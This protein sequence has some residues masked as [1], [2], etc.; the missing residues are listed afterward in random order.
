MTLLS[1]DSNDSKTL[2]DGVGKPHRIRKMDKDVDLESTASVN[3]VCAKDSHHEDDD[4]ILEEDDPGIEYNYVLTQFSSNEQS[5]S[6]SG[7]K[8]QIDQVIQQSITKSMTPSK[9]DATPSKKDV[10]SSIARSVIWNNDDESSNR[11][12]ALQENPT[13]RERRMA[14][15][16]EAIAKAKSNLK[17]RLKQAD[18]IGQQATSIKEQLEADSN[19]VVSMIHHL[20]HIQEEYLCIVID[21]DYVEEGEEGVNVTNRFNQFD[22]QSISRSTDR[23]LNQVQNTKERCDLLSKI[24]M[25]GK[26]TK[27]ITQKIEE[28]DNRMMEYERKIAS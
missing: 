24:N 1:N 2:F 15:V 9:K 23:H 11:G 22:P 12:L 21:E 19:N 16:R 7:T 18:S 10:A 26:T 27:V 20:I 4:E 3:A 28:Y 8:R 13:R 6:I 5:S 14:S 17:I 25:N